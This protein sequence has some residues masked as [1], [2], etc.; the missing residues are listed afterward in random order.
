MLVAFWWLCRLRWRRR[1]TRM[2]PGKQT[3]SLS[4][5]TCSSQLRPSQTTAPSPSCHGAGNAG[6]WS[7][8]GSTLRST[9]FGCTRS[10]KFGSERDIKFVVLGGLHD[11]HS[12]HAAAVVP[13]CG[14]NCECLAMASA[15]A[16]RQSQSIEGTW[17]FVRGYANISCIRL[18]AQASKRR[19]VS[20]RLQSQR[21]KR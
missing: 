4:A 17:K 20:E 11:P 7:F 12:N 21:L 15:N 1:A 16:C 2:L 6:L 8:S 5:S 14:D 19:I 13:V 18:P 10:L 9:G 3:S